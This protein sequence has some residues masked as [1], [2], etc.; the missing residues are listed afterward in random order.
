MVGLAPLIPGTLNDRL[1][2]AFQLVDDEGKGWV[3]KSEM[4][5]CF[6]SM[7]R[8]CGFLSDPEMPLETIEEL[9]ASLFVAHQ[10]G[11]SMEESVEYGDNIAAIAEVRGGGGGRAG[12]KRRED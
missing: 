11:G 10:D 1:L 9:V 12:A 2:L 4:L 6:R 8:C 5:F 3:D 7:S